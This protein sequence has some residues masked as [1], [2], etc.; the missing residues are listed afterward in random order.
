MPHRGLALIR[1][2]GRSGSA[3]LCAVAN[4]GEIQQAWN[5]PNV[6]RTRL[7]YLLR[8]AAAVLVGVVS[9]LGAL[10]VMTVT[11]T[12]SGGPDAAAT[13][14][15]QVVQCTEKGPVSLAGLGYFHRC[16]ADVSWDDGSTS[17]EWFPRG[18]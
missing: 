18:N 5:R 6:Q 9:L 11:D 16:E 2:C 14:T 12:F 17:R 1:P 10:T 3:T 15:A 4:T 7:H 8:C 13:G